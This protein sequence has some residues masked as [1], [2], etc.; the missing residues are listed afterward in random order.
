[1]AQACHRRGLRRLSPPSKN[2]KRVCSIAAA[3]IKGVVEYFFKNSS[4]PPYEFRTT[5][6]SWLQ[7]KGTLI[8]GS[9]VYHYLPEHFNGVASAWLTFKGNIYTC[10]LGTKNPCSIP[11]II[12][13]LMIILVGYFLFLPLPFLPFFPFF[14]LFFSAFLILKALQND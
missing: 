14:F 1:L 10:A 2:M 4:S 5:P 9:T 3:I 7:M 13:P 6:L 11:G 12:T 8:W